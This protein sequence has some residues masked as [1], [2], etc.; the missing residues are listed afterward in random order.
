[1]LS[2]ALVTLIPTTAVT[3]TTTTSPT[4]SNPMNAITT[5]PFT[6][7]TSAKR[8]EGQMKLRQEKEKKILNLNY[9]PPEPIYMH[10][11]E[12]QPPTLVNDLIPA[13]ENSRDAKQNKRENK[14]EE[15]R[16][17]VLEL[18]DE[19]RDLD[20]YSYCESESDYDYHTYV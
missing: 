11:H 20:Y 15:D 9:Y 10:S 14:T 12:E 5:C 16:R 2:R 19:E 7:S 3:T 6:S 1:M 8:K 13:P 4:M 18:L 17:I